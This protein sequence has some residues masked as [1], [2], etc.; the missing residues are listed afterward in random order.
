MFYSPLRYPGGKNRLARLVAQICV[1]NGVDGHYVEPYVGGAAVALYL[2]IEGRVKT[3]T[4]NDYDRSIYAFWYC[5]LNRTDE[6]CERIEKTPVTMPHWREA[7]EIQR[8]KVQADLLDLGFSTFFLNRTNRSGIINAGVIGG[9]SQQGNYK[10]D[11]RFNKKNL[12]ERIRRIAQHKKDITLHHK[13]A[14]EL[15]EDMDQWGYNTIFY[16]DPPYYS[17]GSSLYMNHYND[18]QHKKVADKI[19]SMKNFHWI[20][21]YDDVPQIR[22]MYRWAL[23]EKYLLKHF[24][25][26]MKKGAEILF[27]GHKTKIPN[28]HLFRSLI[29]G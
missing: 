23:S 2:L 11:C 19:K 18:E 1:D 21:S 7:K 14:L 16:F 6:L 15:I 26:K 27:Y 13:D 22:K 5:V 28:A 10:M 4:I 8:N 25:Y 24:A 12:I 9:I 17:K 3:I 20:V 29:T